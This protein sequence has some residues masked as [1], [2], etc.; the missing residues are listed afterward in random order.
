MTQENRSSKR[1]DS[2]DLKKKIQRLEKTIELQ[3]RTIEHDK[4]FMI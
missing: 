4:K 3:Q 2:K 1:E